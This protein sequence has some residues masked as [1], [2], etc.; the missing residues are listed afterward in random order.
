[1]PVPNL[2]RETACQTELLFHAMKHFK[3]KNW[4]RLK[5]KS[6]D[7]IY[8]ALLQHAKEHEMTVKDFNRHKSNGRIV[9][10]TV[11][12]NKISSFIHRNGNSYKAKGGPGKI[13]SKC[14]MS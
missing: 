9:T 12:D 6:E 13:C 14:S 7:V 4:V 1:M 8:A 5:K 11:V 3:V 10:A 2:S